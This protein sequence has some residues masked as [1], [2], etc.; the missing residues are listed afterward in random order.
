MQK[1]SRSLYFYQQFYCQSSHQFLMLFFWINLFEEVLEVL[2]EKNT[3]SC[4]VKWLS[5]PSILKGSL[6]KNSSYSFIHKGQCPR[7]SSNF[8]RLD[9]FSVEGTIKC[10]VHEGKLTSFQNIAKR[11]KWIKKVWKDACNIYEIQKT[12]L[13]FH[14]T[15]IEDSS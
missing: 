4:K 15:R 9:H 13:Q 7:N 3:I 5:I 12:I 2:L 10:K 6:K 8:Y 1:F 14:L 11:K